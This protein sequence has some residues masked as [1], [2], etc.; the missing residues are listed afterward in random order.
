MESIEKFKSFLAGIGVENCPHNGGLECFDVNQAKLITDYFTD[1][2]MLLKNVY[3]MIIISYVKK[4]QLDRVMLF[5][6]NWGGVA[7][8]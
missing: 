6:V 1:R 3:R 5:V 8:C 2:Y 7:A 4:I